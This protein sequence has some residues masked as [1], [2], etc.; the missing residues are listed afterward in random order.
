MKRP[1][2]RSQS[3]QLRQLAIAALNYESSYQK[4]PAQANYSDDGKPLLSWRVHLLP[5]MEQDS[6]YR[7]FKL[8]EPWDSPH[9]IKLLDRNAGDLPWPEFRARQ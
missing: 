1:D 9:N 5:F 3:N 4:F 8:D 2:G 6:L 7:Q